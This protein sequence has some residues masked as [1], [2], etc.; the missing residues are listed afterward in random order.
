MRLAPSHARRG[1]ANLCIIIAVGLKRQREVS[2]TLAGS[3]SA[4]VCTDGDKDSLHSLFYVPF[5]ASS[6][7]SQ[8]QNLQP[9]RREKI[10]LG[11]S[12]GRQRRKKQNTRRT[13]VISHSV[14]QANL[15]SRKS[16]RINDKME[17]NFLTLTLTM[18]I[19]R[20]PWSSE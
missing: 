2:E 13:S 12:D 1:F 10:N 20:A 14:Q 19:S 9:K 5:L 15:S 16:R 4:D 3:R 11:R 6:Q 18:L 7:G 17:W 8:L